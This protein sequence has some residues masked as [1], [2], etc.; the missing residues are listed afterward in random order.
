MKQLLFLFAFIAM[1][2]TAMA[3]DATDKHLNSNELE[4][5]IDFHHTWGL[6]EREM[7]IRIR[8]IYMVIPLV[9]PCCIVS[10]PD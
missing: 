10:H 4:F 8:M 9:F 7:V 2:A 3:Q 5:N 1:G 6:V